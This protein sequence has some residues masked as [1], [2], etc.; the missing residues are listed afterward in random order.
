MEIP[1]IGLGFW[2]IKKED[3]EKVLF[4][5]L[6]AGYRHIDTAIAYDNEGEIG[7]ALKESGQ[8]RET[9]FL[10]SKVPAEIKSYEGAKRA[11]DESLTRLKCGYLDLMLIHAPKPWALMN[12][13]S[14]RFHKENL[15]VWKA[16]SEAKAEG[17]VR[18][19]GVSNFSVSDI[20]NLV[21]HSEETPFANQIRVHV[22]HVDS[23][24]ISFCRERGI[25]V[26]AY[27]PSGTGRLLKNG[28]VVSLA[29]KY[30]VSPAQLCIR[31]DLDLGTIPLPRS[32]NPAHIAENIA[33]DFSLSEEDTKKLDRVFAF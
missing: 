4:A 11:I 6:E 10:T 14:P 20:E 26:E 7:D 21:K 15:A 23:K 9:L 24:T 22:G 32:K 17:K 2:N 28:T 18:R 13:P 12:L 5:G 25:L 19:I 31:Y 16:L 8:K 29:Q 27:S 3:A 1:K 33:V 30:G